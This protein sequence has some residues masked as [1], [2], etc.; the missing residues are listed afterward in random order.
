MS[1]SNLGLSDKVLAAVAAAGYTTPTPI[2][3]QAIPHVLARRDVLGIAQTGTGKTAAFVLPM[4]TLL[5]KGRAR[6]R[7]PRTLILEPTRELAAQVKENFDKYGA[8]QKLNVAL[9]IGGVSFGDQDTKLTRG[10]DV[11][12]ATPGTPARSYR[13]RRAAAHRRR[14]AGHRRSRPHA[15]HGL[16]PGHRAHLQ[17]GPVH[18]PDAVLHGDDADRKSAASPRRSCTIRSASKSRS[19]PPPPSP[20]RSRW[21]PS[22]A[23][24]TRSAKPC[25]SCSA[26]PRTSRTRSSSATASAKSRSC[27]IAAEARLQR[28]SPCTATWTSRPARPRW[29][30]SARARCRCW[31]P[32]T[33]P[34]AA[35]TFP[36]S[37]TSSISTC[38]HHPDDYVHRI[39]R[40][41]RAGRSAP[42]SRSSAAARRE[43]ARRDREADRPDRFPRRRLAGCDAAD[44]ARRRDA[45]RRA[46]TPSA[47]RQRSQQGRAASPQRHAAAA[48]KQA[49]QAATRLSRPRHART[50]ATEARTAAASRRRSAAQRRRPQPRRHEHAEPADH[51]HL[52]AFLLRPVRARG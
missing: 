35:S 22:A 25:G 32:P 9:L 39:G 30:N 38:P 24:R 49:P 8:G 17:A 28:R 16:H 12:I 46:A 47:H 29:T 4:L 13:A 6:A 36:T 41:G 43:V 44:E 27:T 21:S 50:A 14:A 10:V 18:P 42:R 1:F 45:P 15:R 7:M 11:L 26:P 37:A 48:R 19:R 40:T 31:S 52:P 2:Q 23:S 3:E 33:S 5:E 20:S 34:P 51:S